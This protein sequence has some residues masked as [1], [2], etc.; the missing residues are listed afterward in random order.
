M[1]LPEDYTFCYLAT[2][3]ASMMQV[4]PWKYC[5]WKGLSVLEAHKLTPQI[6]SVLFAYC[7]KIPSIELT[8]QN[9]KLGTKLSHYFSNSQNQAGDQTR[10]RLWPSQL[11]VPS[12]C[13]LG[14]PFSKRDLR[15][16]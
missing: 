6:V 4:W 12:V 11:L 10:K 15:F 5:Q 7:F 14:F 1:T 13:F 9:F 8:V 2:Q 16:R 3:P